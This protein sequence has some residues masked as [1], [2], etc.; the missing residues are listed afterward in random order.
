MPTPVALTRA[1]GMS[2]SGR[3]CTQLR[4]T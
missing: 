2:T 1:A 3:A 4:E